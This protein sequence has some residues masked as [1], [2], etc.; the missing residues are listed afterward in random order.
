MAAPV[1]DIVQD[2]KDYIE[3]ESFNVDNS[4]AEAARI[5]QGL[6]NEIERI[7]KLHREEQRRSADRLK[8]ATAKLKELTPDDPCYARGSYMS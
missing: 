4:H 3:V 5:M 7:R 8:E 6:L 2:A 1:T